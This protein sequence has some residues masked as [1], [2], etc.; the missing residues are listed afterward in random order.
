MFDPQAAEISAIIASDG[1]KLITHTARLTLPPPLPPLAKTKFTMR[2][3]SL[4]TIPP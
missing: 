2:A 4:Y 3:G 1:Q